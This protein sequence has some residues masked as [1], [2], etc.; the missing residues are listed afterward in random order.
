MSSSTWVVYEVFSKN[1]YDVGKKYQQT[2]T[3][4]HFLFSTPTVSNLLIC[5]YV[6][7]GLDSSAQCQFS[8]LVKDR[9][10]DWW[11][12]SFLSFQMRVI[13]MFFMR[14]L[15]NFPWK[16]MMDEWKIFVLKM[17]FSSTRNPWGIFFSSS[18]PKAQVSFSDR[19]LSFV[20]RHIFI[21]FSRATGPVSTELG[22]KHPWMKRIQVDVTN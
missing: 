17:F 4:N 3:H 21:F 2:Q 9:A 5:K 12:N 18:E 14:I 7:H 6:F 13:S 8:K 20:R 19:N 10:Q 1:K 15:V 16:E 22:T 11:G